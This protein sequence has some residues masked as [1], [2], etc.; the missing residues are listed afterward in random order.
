MKKDDNKEEEANDAGS[1]RINSPQRQGVASHDEDETLKDEEFSRR[2]KR[3]T[4]NQESH[5]HD[6][7]TEYRTNPLHP[8]NTDNS[9]DGLGPKFVTVVDLN[10]NL[11]PHMLPWKLGSA[12]LLQYILHEKNNHDDEI[13]LL[14]LAFIAGAISLAI[15]IHASFMTYALQSFGTIW[16]YIPVR[17]KRVKMV[18]KIFSGVL[19]VAEAGL[20]SYIFFYCAIHYNSAHEEFLMRE[21]YSDFE[22]A[23]GRKP[24]YVEHKVFLFTFIV[25]AVTFGGTV[26]AIFLSVFLICFEGQLYAWLKSK[27][28][29]RLRGMSEGKTSIPKAANYII[30]EGLSTVLIN[31]FIGMFDHN[32][33]GYIDNVIF[34]G[35]DENDVGEAIYLKTFSLAVGMITMAMSLF[36][37]IITYAM[38]ISVRDGKLDAIEVKL[39][40]VFHVIRYVMAGVQVILL[41]VMLYQ[42]SV[43][44]F[45]VV[46]TKQ[47]PYM[48]PTNLFN[49]TFVLSLFVVVAVFITAIEIIYMKGCRKRNLNPTVS[50]I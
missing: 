14:T 44:T 45:G 30:D 21:A 28:P 29:R 33:H 9:N 4:E 25:S 16:S 11:V 1:R 3:A 43:T 38:Q 6:K 7:V 35:I 8:D 49:L 13:G 36:N 31:V 50:M 23:F 19:A 32:N 10:L 34:L 12:L 2:F 40:Q 24:Y 22:T 17:V 37:T 42:A 47:G 46:D 27:Y 48:G 41:G 5:A 20:V 18:A 39:I 15:M 26:I